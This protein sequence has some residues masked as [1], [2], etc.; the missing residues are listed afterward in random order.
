[1]KWIKNDTCVLY[2]EDNLDLQKYCSLSSSQQSLYTLYSVINHNGTLNDGHYTTFCR[3]ITTNQ[4][5]WIE[6]DDETINY[7]HSEKLHSNS[8]AYLLFYIMEKTA[9]SLDT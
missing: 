1:M 5:Q 8:K 7:L 2:P 6:C 4:R 3:D 9:E